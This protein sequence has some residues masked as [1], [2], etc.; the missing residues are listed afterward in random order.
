MDFD[1]VD[2]LDTGDNEML[3]IWNILTRI[4]WYS[5]FLQN[6]VADGRVHYNKVSL[7]VDFDNKCLY[8]QKLLNL[9]R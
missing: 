1:I 6:N 4:P 8:C 3:S 7:Y 9:A 2:F 5:G